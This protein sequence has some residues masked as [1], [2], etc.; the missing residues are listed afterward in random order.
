M[1]VA[2]NFPCMGLLFSPKAIGFLSET[3]EHRVGIHL[4]EHSGLAEAAGSRMG[5]GFA[6][7]KNDVADSSARE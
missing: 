1:G 5:E 4:P 6:F 3:A 2:Q 7:K